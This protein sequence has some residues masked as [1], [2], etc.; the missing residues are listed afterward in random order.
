MIALGNGHYRWYL[1]QKRISPVA[2]A[3]VGITEMRITCRSGKPGARG[4]S[5]VYGLKI[6]KVKA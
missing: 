6:G 4:V 3:W 1:D 5:L 2:R